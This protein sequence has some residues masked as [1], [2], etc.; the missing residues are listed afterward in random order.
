M[1]NALDPF[2]GTKEKIRKWR[3]VGGINSEGGNIFFGIKM[4]SMSYRFEEGNEPNRMRSIEGQAYSDESPANIRKAL[5]KA[6]RISESSFEISSNGIGGKAK[7]DD[8]SLCAYD[9]N[10]IVILRGNGL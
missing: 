10:Y 8:L 3:D 5:A 9:G 7:S 1:T 6:C 4:E 2:T